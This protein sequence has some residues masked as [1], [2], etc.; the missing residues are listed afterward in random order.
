[1]ITI[2]TKSM[3]VESESYPIMNANSTKATVC[4]SKNNSDT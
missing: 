2:N 4:N 1:M 3:L